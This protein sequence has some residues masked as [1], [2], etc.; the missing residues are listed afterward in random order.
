MI[1]LFRKTRQRLLTENKFTKYL[2]YAAGEIILVVV[3]ILIALSINNSNE[4]KKTRR[5]E[6]KYLKNLQTD[7]G[8][9]IIN[10]DSL[11]NYRAF[12]AKAAARILDFKTLESVNDIMALEQN[13]NQVFSRETF[14]PTN[15][16]FKELLSSGNLSYITNDSIKD[17]LLEL[18]KMYVSIGNGEHHM[19]REYE[20]YLYNV[21]IKNGPV[22][23]LLDVQKIAA[24]GLFH[25]ADPLQIPV[26]TVL[27]DY[28]RLLK[29]HEFRNGLKL[30]VMNNIGLKNIHGVMTQHLKKLNELIQNDLENN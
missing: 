18:D 21:S 1:K 5:Q 3:G 22:L 4:D 13:V 9:E 19:Y 30:S 12:T 17:Y 26:E 15:N 28:N 2:L 20:E 29:K 25:F 24:T 23:N 6:V 8:L 14:I 10:N 27:S 11:I 16:T 7:I